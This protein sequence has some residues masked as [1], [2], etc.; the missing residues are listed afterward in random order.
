MKKIQT[1]LL[2]LAL[3]IGVSAC[4]RGR[5]VFIRSSD[6]RNTISVKYSGRVIFADDNKSISS[7]SPGSY[8]EFKKNDDEISAHADNNGRIF[9]ELNDGAKSTTPDEDGKQLLQE[10]A[11]QVMKAQG[12]RI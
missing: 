4:N 1:T 12:K 11:R 8:F 10:A 2:A 6:G 9:Y 5:H 7:M 3:L